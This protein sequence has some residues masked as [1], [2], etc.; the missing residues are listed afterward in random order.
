RLISQKGTYLSCHSNWGSIMTQETTW[1]D[2]YKTNTGTLPWD[3]GTPAPELTSVM[4]ELKLPN[5]RVLEVGCGTGTNAVW[6]AQK[7][8]EV[9]ATEVAPTALDSAKEKASAAQVKINFKLS[10]ICEEPPI[11]KQSVGFVFDRGVFHTMPADKRA[12][13]VER[14]ADSLVSGGYWLCLA[15]SADETQATEGPP[16]LTAATIVNAVEPRFEIHK[17]ERI[18]F[19]IPGIGLHLAWLGLFA[20]R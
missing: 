17:L 12:V 4:P 18:T 3:I 14:V 10:D 11:E 2:R 1:E 16:K 9:T 15:G 20:V 19:T 13:F 7:G 5:N 8:Y 6:L